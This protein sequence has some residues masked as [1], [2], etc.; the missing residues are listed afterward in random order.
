MCGLAAQAADSVATPSSSSTPVSSAS[1][2]SRVSGRARRDRVLALDAVARME[3]VLGP[4]AVVGEEDQALGVL[5]EAA[6]RVEARAAGEL[7]RD[8][9][10]DGPLGVAVLDGRG[11]AGRLV[12][13]EVEAV[14][15]RGADRAGRRPR[16]AAPRGST[17][18][19]RTAGRPSTVTRPA[20]TSS[21]APRRD[22]T[23]AAARTLEMRSAG[24]GQALA[25]DGGR[26]G[27]RRRRRPG[28]SVA[29]AV[30]SVDE[31]RGHVEVERRQ[32]LEARHAEP[33][34]ELEARAVQD[35]AARRLGAALLDD[36]AAVEQ[37][38]DR[39]VRVD[40]ADPLDRR[41]S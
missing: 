40:A 6:D 32:V 28:R 5:V 27:R 36:E 38:P 20:A 33:L 22:A 21:S 18:S 19:P 16:S 39:V 13:G 41:P 11:D 10:H 9:V 30:R 26:R 3:D 35:R 29:V 8:E 14:L 7:A 15:G 23:P 2:C 17:F 1:A 31:P 24:T 25:V 34:E 4:V 12:E 37:R